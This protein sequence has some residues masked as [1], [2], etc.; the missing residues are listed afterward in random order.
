[1]L[2]EMFY[3]AVGARLQIVEAH[4]VLEGDSKVGSGWGLLGELF[5]RLLL[6][7]YKLLL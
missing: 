6:Y 2:S 4:R 1:M 3:W 7:S 5:I